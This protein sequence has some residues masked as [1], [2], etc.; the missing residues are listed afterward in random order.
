MSHI[1]MCI[2]IGFAKGSSFNLRQ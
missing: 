1:F 2:L